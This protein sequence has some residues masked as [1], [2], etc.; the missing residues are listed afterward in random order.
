MKL[1]FSPG[2]CSLAPHIVLREA[3]FEFTPV[4]ASTK[5]KKLADGSDFLAINS[6]GQVPVLELDDGDGPLQ[7]APFRCLKRLRRKYWPMS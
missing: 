2:A 4:L 5:T 3:G 7:Q 6:K 1:Y